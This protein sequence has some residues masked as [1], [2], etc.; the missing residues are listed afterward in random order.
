MPEENQPTSDDFYINDELTAA[1][2]DS[3]SPTRSDSDGPEKTGPDRTKPKTAPDQKDR[4]WIE[5]SQAEV[6]G[7]LKID[8]YETED[9]I[10]VRAPVPGVDKDNIELSLNDSTIKIKCT[11][12]AKRPEDKDNSVNYLI[13]ECSWGEMTRSFDISQPIKEEKIDASLTGDGILTIVFVKIKQE[14]AVR[15]INIK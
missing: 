13:Q 11:S 9:E 15:K 4:D 14:D 1:F 12:Q 10:I 2:L 7:Q 8:V 6:K 5:S 3:D